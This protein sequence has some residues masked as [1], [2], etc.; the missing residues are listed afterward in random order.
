MLTLPKSGIRLICFQ[1]STTAEMETFLGRVIRLYLIAKA[2][3][4]GSDANFAWWWRKLP[5]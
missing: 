5:A 1:A 2:V 3:Y 4:F